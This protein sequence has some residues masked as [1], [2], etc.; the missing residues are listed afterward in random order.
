M[1]NTTTLINRNRLFAKEYSGAE[2]PVIPRLRTVILT[3]GDSR[4]DPAHV[5]GLDLGDAVVIRNNGGRVTPEVI[6]DS[7]FLQTFALFLSEF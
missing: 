1:S 4:V 3:C 2:L 6:E 7:V 5:F